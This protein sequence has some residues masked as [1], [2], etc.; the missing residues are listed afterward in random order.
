MRRLMAGATAVGMA[1][2][3]SACG[4]GPSPEDTVEEFAQA[5]HDQDFEKVC[6]L[7]DPETVKTT[8]EAGGGTSCPDTMKQ[9]AEMEDQGALLEDPD[10]LEIGEAK[11]ADD[12][13]TA[14]VPTTYDGNESEI[15]LVK[16][17]DE[18]K[19]TFG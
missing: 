1:L 9:A 17:D 14:T 10:K 2:A 3:L 16:V 6:E 5:A 11:I 7:L 4:G 19:V 12:E 15:T 8:E 13:K 18:W